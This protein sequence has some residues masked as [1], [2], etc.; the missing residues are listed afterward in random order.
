MSLP[1]RSIAIA[2][3][4]TA[5]LGGCATKGQLRRGLEEQ[6]A[7]LAA[8]RQA[9]E[10]ADTRLAA[11]MERLRTDLETL[12]TEFGTQITALEKGMQFMVPVHFAFDRAE[13]RPDAQPVLNRFS[14]VVQ[15]HYP[16][17]VITVEGFADPAGSAAYNRALSLRRA[18]AVRTYLSQQGLDFTRLQAVGYGEDRLVVPR[19][20]GD[21]QGA[22]LNRRVVFVVETPANAMAATQTTLR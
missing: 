15:R 19:A 11:D 8:E 2:V 16:G 6:R 4:G 3:L 12:R 13:I 17:A 18:E 1:I 20:A 10:A 21:D 9:R 14:E 22:Q 5:V 7:A